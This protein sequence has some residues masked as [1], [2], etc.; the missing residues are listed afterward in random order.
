MPAIPARHISPDTKNGLLTDLY[1]CPP[2]GQIL[3]QDKS[4]HQGSK[5]TRPERLRKPPLVVLESWWF[6][7]VNALLL[8]RYWLCLFGIEI[9]K[10]ACLALFPAALVPGISD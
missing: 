4:N 5:D 1:L 6:F 8:R 2:L 10:S 9:R 7:L 3:K